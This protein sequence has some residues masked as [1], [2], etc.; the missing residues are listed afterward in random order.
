MNTNEE[1]LTRWIDGEA[2]P[3]GLSAARRAEIESA[4]RLGSVIRENYPA[5][6]DVP[7]PELFMHQLDHRLDRLAEE[8]EAASPQQRRLW[9]LAR[10]SLAAAA[11]LV[12]GVVGM[13]W[14]GAP[15]AGAGGL[16]ST[17]SPD[18][19]LVVDA[20]FDSSVGAVVIVIDGMAP[21]ERVDEVVG[22][23]GTSPQIAAVRPADR[24]R[25][26]APH[27]NRIQTRARGGAP[28]V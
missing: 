2:T 9:W 7:G 20:H 3:A 27:R 1:D 28:E 4:R 8:A 26:S 22:V 18:S 17:F 23:P 12:L 21:V 24:A 5:E 11:A 25:A 15:Q 13:Q 16:I 19:S 6:L 14:L 10:G